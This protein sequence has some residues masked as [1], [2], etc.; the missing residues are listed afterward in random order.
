VTGVRHDAWANAH[1]VAVES[2]K[3]KGERGLFL[4]PTELG[5]AAEKGIDWERSPA[6]RRVENG[7][8]MRTSPGSS[9]DAVTDRNPR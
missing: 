4:H 8:A 6:S 2:V 7:Q 3:P 1:R 9:T 5:K